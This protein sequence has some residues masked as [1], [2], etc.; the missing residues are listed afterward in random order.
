MAYYGYATFRH[1]KFSIYPLPQF[2]HEDRV[3][4]LDPLGSFFIGIAKKFWGL[5]AYVLFWLICFAWAFNFDGPLDFMKDYE[6]LIVPFGV[7]ALVILVLQ[8]TAALLPLWTVHT[9]LDDLKRNL[10]D[11]SVKRSRRRNKLYCLF[12]EGDT[13]DDTKRK[14]EMFDVWLTAYEAIPT[15]PV[16]KG[17]FRQ[18]WILWGAAL[19]SV[20]IT[21]LSLLLNLK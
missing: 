8:A 9:R 14:I 7:L 13:S 10:S 18:F 21:L 20:V 19:T 12:F 1:Q 4:G 15:W 17:T 16:E 11:E 2:G 3:L 6:E 5:S